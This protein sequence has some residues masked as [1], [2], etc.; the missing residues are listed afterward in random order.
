MHETIQQQLLRVD[1]TEHIMPYREISD[2][3]C[4]QGY[5]QCC[6]K[7]EALKKKYKEMLEQPEV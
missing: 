2:E 6:K 7:I 4:R 5:K 1:G 3:L